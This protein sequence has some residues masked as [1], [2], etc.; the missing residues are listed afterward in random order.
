[1]LI[2]AQELDKHR[3]TAAKHHI[4]TQAIATATPPDPKPSSRSIKPQ[5]SRPQSHQQQDPAL[6]DPLIDLLL[7]LPPILTPTST[8]LPSSSLTLLLS[9]PPL[10]NLDD[11][12]PSLATT[13]SPTLHSSALTLTRLAHPSTN[14]SY[15]H[16]QIPSLPNHIL[17]NL[18]NAHTNL[19]TAL[20]QSR[21]Q[22]LSS[23]LNLLNSHAATITQLI[24]LLEVKHGLI[25][26][27]LELRAADAALN[28]Q[29]TE[30]DAE[31]ALWTIRREV[32]SPEARQALR[33]YGAHLKDARMRTEEKLRVLKME[34]SDYGVGVEGAEAKERTMR[35]MARVYSQMGRQMQD[36]KGDLDR[37]QRG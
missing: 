20:T 2:M 30:V 11:L 37:L 28:S 17:T 34:L 32:Y 10:S 26:R 25:A 5:P 27:N 8:P 24:R 31:Q 12:L 18:L 13:I 22:T 1:M 16:R 15:L 36:T 3:L 35:E 7:I 29:R 4:L 6:P 23:L 21:L 33:N 19:Q 14:P 9:S